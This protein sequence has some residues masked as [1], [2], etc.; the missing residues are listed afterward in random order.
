MMNRLINNGDLVLD[1][2][3]NIGGYTKYLS[4]LVG[5]EGRVFSIEPVPITYEILSSNVKKLKLKNVELMNCAIS[6][7]NARVELDIPKYASG[8]ENYYQARIVE[9]PEVTRHT[10]VSVDSKRLDTIFS[11]L[12]GKVSFIKCDVEGHELKVIKGAAD[13]IRNS[14][15]ALY[16]E[17]SS[18]PDDPHSPA[19]EAF[20]LLKREGYEAY[21]YDGQCLKRRTSGDYR[22]N[23]FFLKGKHIKTL[24][25]KHTVKIL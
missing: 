14:E 3:A 2:G 22:V 12:R 6:D 24:E 10:R 13:L 19:F 17:I 4:E 20:R 1:I 18:N 7:R 9:N 21:Q 25:G 23:Y 15:P 16:F 5:T 11:H 8:L